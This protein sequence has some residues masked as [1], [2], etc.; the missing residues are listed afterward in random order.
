[1]RILKGKVAIQIRKKKRK[2]EDLVFGSRDP[3]KKEFFERTRRHYFEGTK[4]GRARKR[5]AA[6][7]P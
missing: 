1:M 2:Q 7:P 4:R 5:G 3:R 6:A